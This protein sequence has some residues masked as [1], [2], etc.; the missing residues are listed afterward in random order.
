MKKIIKRGPRLYIYEDE[1][2]MAGYSSITEHYWG[3][4]SYIERLREFV[5]SSNG[6]LLM[7]FLRV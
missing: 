7:R 1:N 5:E 4:T 3:A 2:K 6:K